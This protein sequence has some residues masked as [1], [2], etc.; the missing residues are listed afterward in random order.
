MSSKTKTTATKEEAT[1]ALVPK[2][3][4]PEF[5][6][7]LG[8]DVGRIADIAEV[9]QGYGFPERYQGQATGEYPFYKVSDISN[10]LAA[11][12][13]YISE[14][15]NYITEDVLRELKAKPIPEGATIF[16]KIGEAIRSNRRAITTKSCLIDNNAAGVKRIQGKSTDLFV[17]FTMETISLIDYSGGVVPSVNKSAIENIEVKFPEIEEQQKIAECLSSVD[18]LMAAQARKVDALKTHKK[19]LMQQLFPREGETQ[20]RLRFPEF[21]DAGAWKLDTLE[22]MCVAKISYGIVQAGPHVPNGMPYIKSTDLNAELCLANLSRTSD[23]IADRYR[24]SEVIP[25]D[26]VFSLR[27]NIGVSQIVP[28]GIPVANLTQGTARIRTEGPS[29]FYLH[30]LRSQ[31]VHDRILAV[32]K[33]STFQEVSLEALREI[34]L[35]RPALAEQQRIAD[36]LTSLDDLIAAQ[37][38][39]LAALKTHKKGLMQQLFPSP[40]DVEA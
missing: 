6:D 11:G 19:G 30:A 12:K 26:I 39:K 24:R 5:R 40:E 8:W 38:Q 16:A 25:G 18:E 15:A 17:Y 28:K 13:V 23:V 7:A 10:T 4:F 34:P 21:Q 35:F 29:E 22:N 9:L 32:G 20:P 36:C 33:G 31:A 3:R 27:G 2:L 14:S 37:T 1:P